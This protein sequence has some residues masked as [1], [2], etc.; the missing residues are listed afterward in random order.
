M[1]VFMSLAKVFPALALAACTSIPVS[2]L[3]ALSRV[4]FATTRIDALR[5][6]VELPSA[7]APE[8]DG[9]HLEVTAKLGEKEDKFRFKLQKDVA[10]I[11]MKGLLPFPE[12]GKQIYAYRLRDEDVVTLAKL[13]RDRLENKQKGEK[14]SLSIGVSAKEFC[15]NKDIRNADLTLTTYIATSETKGF[16]P[17]VRN[18]DVRGDKDISAALDHLPL[19]K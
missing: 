2:S 3:M 14:G 6:A 13:R 11:G 7:I 1:R 17:V 5:V 12:E 16:V 15:R 4:D 10:Q 9:V 19:C 8:E 18:Y